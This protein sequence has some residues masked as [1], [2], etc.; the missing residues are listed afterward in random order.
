[1]VSRDEPWNIGKRCVA[2]GTPSEVER[3]ILDVISSVGQL[4]ILLL[5]RETA[6]RQWTAGSVARE[7]RFAV[8]SVASRLEDLRARGLLALTAEEG[9]V[10][11]FAPRDPKD[12]DVVRAVAE[13]YETRRVSVITLIYSRPSDPVRQ[14]ADAFKIRKKDEDG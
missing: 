7:L 4:E 9:P 10:Y 5:L 11:Y 8:E 14:F 13:M 3:F 6:P 12:A 2:E 1:M